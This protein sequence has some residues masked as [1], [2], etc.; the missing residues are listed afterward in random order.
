MIGS[1]GMIVLRSLRLHKLSTAVTAVAIALSAGLAMAV[2]S[3][4]M[5]SSTAFGGGRGG[6]DAVLGAKGSA[7]QLVLN[8]IYHLET[9]PGN[10]PWSMYQ[11]IREHPTVTLAVP[12]AVGDNYRGYRIVGTTTELFSEFEYAE[13]KKYELTPNQVFDPMR[14]EAVLGA[15]VARELGIGRGDVFQP[16]HGVIDSAS[17]EVHD[18]DYHV[19]SVMEPT[20]TPAD[21][22]IWIPIE[23]VFRMPGHSFFDEEGNELEAGW[24]V[25]IPDKYKEV[26]AVM[27]QVRPGAGAFTLMNQINRQGDVA[28]F[29]WPVAAIMAKLLQDLGWVNRILEAVAYL[30]VLVA[31]GGLLAAL[32]NTM[33]ERRREFAILRALGASRRTVFTVIV[34][35]SATVAAIG[36]V[37]GFGVYFGILVLAAAQVKQTT[38]VVLDLSLVHPSLYWTPVG[39]V[40]LGALAGLLPA[41]KA[42]STDVAGNLTRA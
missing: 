34:A 18:V 37:L 3:I 24:G 33:N 32:Y 22:V 39:M 13:G 20:N 30:I 10:I 15:T 25:E 2:F 35:E 28:T 19:V 23:G 26:S 42:Y 4:S 11:E 27:L 36:A 6:W 38:G 8:T 7:T 12:Y 5:Q 16:T 31:G 21:K 41:F 14:G 40:V 1:L 17:A 9:S 29:V